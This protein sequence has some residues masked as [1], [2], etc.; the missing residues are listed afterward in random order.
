[1]GLCWLR[2]RGARADLSLGI[3]FTI[4]HQFELGNGPIGAAVDVQS[5]QKDE[6]SIAIL[7]D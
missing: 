5:V 4:A 3:T 1:M 2:A 6:I 7:L